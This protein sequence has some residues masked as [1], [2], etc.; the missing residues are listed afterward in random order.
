M[1][2]ALLL[3]QTR[4]PAEMHVQLERMAKAQGHTVA[5]LLR[6]LVAEATGERTM[7]ARL[8][9]LEARIKRLEEAGGR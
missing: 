7:G 5:G 8:R 1:S 9:E 4:I 2:N 3:V 6:M